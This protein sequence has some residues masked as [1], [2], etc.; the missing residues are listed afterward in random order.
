MHA[1]AAPN[2]DCLK[3]PNGVDTRTELFEFTDSTPD[4]TARATR[5]ARPPSRV[6]IEPD[7]PYGVSFASS[8]ASAS[9][10]NR[11]TAATGPKTSSRATRS[12]LV[13][14]TSVGGNQNPGRRA[15]LHE[16]DV[17][18]DVRRYAFP[19]G[20]DERPHLRLLQLGVADLD[21]RVASTSSS[22]KRS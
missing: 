19:L 18:V 22:R 5:S 8:T 16:D 2:P 12:S 9:S 6:Q 1:L 10:S 11:I 21:P 17:P 14:S 7:S 4:S 20:G 15:R 3:P 13:A